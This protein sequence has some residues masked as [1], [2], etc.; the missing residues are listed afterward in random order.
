MPVAQGGASNILANERRKTT[1][2]SFPSLCKVSKLRVSD[3]SLCYPMSDF[4]CLDLFYRQRLHRK[5][6]G[7]AEIQDAPQGCA[8]QE[9]C[10]CIE[11]HA[12]QT[13]RQ[14]HGAPVLFLRWCSFSGIIGDR[15]A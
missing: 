8:V 5:V 3:P 7:Q 2:A 13:F 10:S 6:A 4:R 15:A 14:E 12:T 11:A 9:Q 1:N